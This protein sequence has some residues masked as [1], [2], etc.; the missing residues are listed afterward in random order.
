[1]SNPALLASKVAMATSIQSGLLAFSEY[2]FDILKSSTI[3][4]AWFLFELFEL[5][6]FK[7]LWVYSAEMSVIKRRQKT[8]KI[9]TKCDILLS[10]GVNTQNRKIEGREILNN[11]YALGLENR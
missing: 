4:N 10:F 9:E 8:Y 5:G 6:I 3:E 7:T 1:V 2:E 11:F